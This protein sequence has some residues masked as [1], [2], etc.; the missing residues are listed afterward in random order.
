VTG[1]IKYDFEPDFSCDNGFGEGDGSK[2]NDHRDLD[3]WRAAMTLS[4][5]TYK[6]TA[7]FPGEERYGLTSQMRRASVSIPANI[8][9]GHGRETTG[10]FVNFLRIAK[11]SAR[12]LETLAELA[13]DFGYLSTEDWRTI[14]SSITRISKM[15]SRLIQSLERRPLP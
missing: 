1:D 2:V 12:E 13:R 6:A 14:E 9:E 7:N 15:L 4:R 11:G 10:A 8:A 3:V 5:D